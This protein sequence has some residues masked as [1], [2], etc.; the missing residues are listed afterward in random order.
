LDPS[1]ELY[2]ILTQ[3]WT[4]PGDNN[5][6]R[7]AAL[8]KIAK[9]YQTGDAYRFSKALVNAYT[10]LL[11]REQPDLIINSVTPGWIQT[12]M[13]AGSAAKGT[14]QQGSVPPVWLLMS[15]DLERVPTGRYYGSDCVRSPLHCYRGPGDEPYDGPDGL[16]IQKESMVQS[17]K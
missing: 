2:Q 16:A 12:D 5:Y 4:I 7:F 14:P 15:P 9:E 11:A 3:P 8:D 10:V 13:T 6:L 17:Q 1:D